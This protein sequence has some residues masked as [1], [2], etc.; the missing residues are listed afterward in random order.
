MPRYFFHLTGG[1]H[2]RLADEVGEEF[3][4]EESARG[5]AM[6]V[7]VDATCVLGCIDVAMRASPRISHTQK[8]VGAARDSTA[9]NARSYPLEIR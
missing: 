5:H 8:R 7:G 1:D 6:A 2:F 4:R 9:R 3:D